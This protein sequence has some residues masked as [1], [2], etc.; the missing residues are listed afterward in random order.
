MNGSA[1]SLSIDSDFLPEQ[2]IS[3]AAI[4]NKPRHIVHGIIPERDNLL[5]TAR[6][7]DRLKEQDSSV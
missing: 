7:M 3:F 5:F 4:N 6:E 2:G 1:R